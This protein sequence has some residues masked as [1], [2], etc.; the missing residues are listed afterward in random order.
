M[1]LYFETSAVKHAAPDDVDTVHVV[2]V[3]ALGTVILLVDHVLIGAGDDPKLIQEGM[4]LVCLP[5][6]ALFLNFLTCFVEPLIY[7]RLGVKGGV[8]GFLLVGMVLR[9]R[10]L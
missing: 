10:C 3:E 6:P 8:G 2:G 5:G 1:L 7:R 4:V 9:A